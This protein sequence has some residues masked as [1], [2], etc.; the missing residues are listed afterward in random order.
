MKRV[1]Y[2]F[3]I[4][5][6]VLWGTIGIYSKQLSQYGAS[7]LHIVSIR[8]IFAALAIFI[9]ILLKDKKHLNIDI[10]DWKYFFGTGILSFVFFN[11]CYFIAINKTTLSTAAILL[12]TAPAIVMVFS[13]I[14]FKEKLTGRKVAA[15]IL[16]FIGCVFV[17]GVIKGKQDISPLGI[18]AGMGSGFGYALYSVF[19]RYA[20]RKYDPITVTF[21]T[22]VFASVGL[23]P[24]SDI[25]GLFCLLS[26][27]GAFCNAI[28]LG[29]AA[30][31]LPFL[32]YT[33]GLSCLE[34]SKASIIATIEPVVATVIG[35]ILFGEPITIYKII[36]VFL[37]VFAVS[38]LEQK[39]ENV[40][41]S[42]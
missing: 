35:I 4:S 25:K 2:V 12:Y 28:L 24:I 15:L 30:T 7:V 13:I 10:H 29:L 37:V 22:F 18:L 5:A 6:A 20:L 36:G 9:F 33:K 17:T 39:K 38:I 26:N 3:V 40:Q 11:W 19:G 16:T 42:I 23:I 34:T 8:A 32:L 1:A 14:L 27:T 31:V 21:Y 41:E